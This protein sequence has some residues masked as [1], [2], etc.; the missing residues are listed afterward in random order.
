MA[1][2]NERAER[3]TTAKDFRG[4]LSPYLDD[5]TY[6]PDLTGRLVRTRRHGVGG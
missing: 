6:Q 2:K 3:I 1:S 4:D 5:Y